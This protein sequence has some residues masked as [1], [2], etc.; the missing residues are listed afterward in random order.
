MR[1]QLYKNRVMKHHNTKILESGTY[2]T[3]LSTV[4]STI[5]NGLFLNNGIGSP[6]NVGNTW[7]N[8]IFTDP[9]NMT[10]SV[11]FG[12]TMVVDILIIAGGGGGG[13]APA[14][15]GGGGGGGG[16]LILYRGLTMSAGTYS[17]LVGSGGIGNPG[18]PGATG[19][20]GGNSSIS[21]LT[22]A[23]G[24]YGGC[25]ST[26]NATNGGT[27]SLFPIPIS[28]VTDGG[29]GGNGTFED[30][31]PG[32][33]SAGGDGGSGLNIGSTDGITQYSG[34][35]P[36]QPGTTQYS[37]GGGGGGGI[38][39]NTPGFPGVAG[40]AGDGGGGG[41]YPSGAGGNAQSGV[42]IIAWK[43]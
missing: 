28:G 1:I 24:G 26:L 30:G 33:S 23:K 19:G 8:I 22:I 32:S 10:Q 12:S 6:Q 9:T 15:Y 2:N 38:T 37:C 35:N 16:D 5:Y 11:H 41:S 21:G 18:F 40:Y 36:G 31:Y 27:N 7:R 43:I 25:S 13:S 29:G 3:P 20:S 14:H 34:G 39:A 17:I 42:V 4:P